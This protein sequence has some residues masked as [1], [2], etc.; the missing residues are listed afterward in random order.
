[1][2]ELLDRDL[3][4]TAVFATNDLMAIGAMSTLRRS[5]LHVP[6]D[7]SLIGFDNIFLASAMIPALTTIEQPVNE[8]GQACV[9]LLLD[10]ILKRTT[11]PRVAWV[12]T[13]LIER[14]SCRPLTAPVP[15]SVHRFDRALL[16]GATE[17]DSF[18]KSAEPL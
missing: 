17:V 3:G 10:Q 14:E 18:A 13:R 15:Y 5:G 16:E 2:Q 6:E 9:R 4:L 1:M 7:V 8:L 11:E 12:P